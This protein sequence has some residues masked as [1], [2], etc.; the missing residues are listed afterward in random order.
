VIVVQGEVRGFTTTVPM[1]MYF[2]HA[3]GKRQVQCVA[4]Q[5]ARGGGAVL[6]E[7]SDACAV[8]WSAAECS[9]Q[10]VS[11]VFGALLLRDSSGE[12]MHLPVEPLLEAAVARQLTGALPSCAA[13]LL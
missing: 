13:V 12:D 5:H 7:V 3:G 8:G 11:P 2:M 4:W 10:L 6:L 1:R 9:W